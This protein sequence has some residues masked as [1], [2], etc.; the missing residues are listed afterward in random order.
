MG[1]LL[2]VTIHFYTISIFISTI[3]NMLPYQEFIQ[4]CKEG[5]L[6][7]VKECIETHNI[8]PSWNEYEGIRWASTYGQMCVVKYLLTLLH[9]DDPNNSEDCAIRYATGHGHIDK[10]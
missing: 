2:Y 9:D 8:K 10:P 1:V 4:G 6:F 7:R 3:K 5:D